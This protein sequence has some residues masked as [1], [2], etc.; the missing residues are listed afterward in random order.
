MDNSKFKPG[1]Y[2]QAQVLESRHLRS[3]LI[4]FWIVL[5]LTLEIVDGGFG[6]VAMES[7]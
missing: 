2:A 6:L 5:E 7:N 4:E 1:M 3:A